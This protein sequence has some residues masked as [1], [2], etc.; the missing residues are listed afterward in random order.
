[1]TKVFIFNIHVHIHMNKMEEQRKHRHITEIGLTLLTQS[2]LDMSYWWHAFQCVFYSI[3]RLS[4]SIL[5]DI[6]PYECLFHREPDYNFLKPFGCICYPYLRPYNN[7]KLSFRS[8]A[9]IFLG[10]SS[11]HKGY[12]C[13]NKSGRIFIARNVVF[14]ES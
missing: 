11:H 10:C 13:D 6:S 3:N 14:N 1:M 8:E 2:S 9:C 7:H 4:T 5:D 12:I